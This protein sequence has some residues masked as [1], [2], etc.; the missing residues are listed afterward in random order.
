MWRF[1]AVFFHSPQIISAVNFFDLENTRIHDNYIRSFQH[2]ID[3][4]I[5]IGMRHRCFWHA[6][7]IL[8]CMHIVPLYVRV[9]SYVNQT[10][11]LYNC[12]LNICIVY[13]LNHMFQRPTTVQVHIVYTLY[14][15]VWNY[16]VY[17]CVD[18]ITII[19]ISRKPGVT[20]VRRKMYRW[21]A[22]KVPWSV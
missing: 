12:I 4:I 18:I 17:H 19:A 5:E 15:G 20:K 3:Y 14:L 13:F 11:R 10:R 21:M 1:S 22:P 8:H 9:F 7:Y 16:G 6:Y 2:H